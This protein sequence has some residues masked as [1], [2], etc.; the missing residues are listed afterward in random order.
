MSFLRGTCSHG[1]WNPSL[2]DIWRALRCPRLFCSPELYEN[3]GK[4]LLFQGRSF[5]ALRRRRRD[6]LPS[7]TSTRVRISKGTHR[8]SEKTLIRRIAATSTKVLTWAG[9][10]LAQVLFALR[11][12][13][14]LWLAKMFG[15]MIASSPVF[16]KPRLNTSKSFCAATS[17]VDS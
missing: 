9:K 2:Y 1:P 3:E 11:R 15:L 14:V 10:I 7:S 8:Y 12:K 13:T 4:G 16:A 5:T 17:T 6:G